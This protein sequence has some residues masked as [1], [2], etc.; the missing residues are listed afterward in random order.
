MA[1]ALCTI[2]QLPATG[3]RPVPDIP[4]R[5]VGP[6]AVAARRR[7]TALNTS[8]RVVTHYDFWSGNL[9]WNDATVTGVVDWSGARSGP[10]GIDIAWSR[11]DLV[12]QGRPRAAQILLEEYRK[13]SRTPLVDIA[14][15]DLQ[16]AAQAEDAVGDWASNY[17]GIGL[18]ELTPGVLRERLRAWAAPF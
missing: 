18:H 15:W 17:A 3:L 4:P 2:H 12:L 16:A 9:L 13:L 5:G 7:F 6:L 14:E 8:E 11:Q 10:R 1:G